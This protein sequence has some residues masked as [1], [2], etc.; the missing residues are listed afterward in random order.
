MKE[1]NSK[2]PKLTISLGNEQVEEKTIESKLETPVTE[3]PASPSLQ[4]L[5]REQATEEDLPMTKENFSLRRIIGGDI[6]MAEAVRKQVWLFILITFFL[7]IYISQRYSYDKYIT[8]IANLEIELQ[9]A[10]NKAL[11]ST[12]ELTE[13]TR[14]SKI[15]DLLKLNNDSTLQIA[16]RPP[17]IIQVEE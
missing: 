6:L 4:Q 10:K 15:L 17:Y 1:D 11:S 12:S 16:D 14:Q 5:I 9:D 3:E 13:S 8:E 7:L 2:E